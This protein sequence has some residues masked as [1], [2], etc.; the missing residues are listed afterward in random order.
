MR[1]QTFLIKNFQ[2]MSL[3]P[4]TSAKKLF[5]PWILGQNVLENLNKQGHSY[6]I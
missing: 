6:S 5:N 3:N 4:L 1:N 2:E